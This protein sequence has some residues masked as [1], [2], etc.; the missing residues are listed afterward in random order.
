MIALYVRSLTTER[1]VIMLKRLQN[2]V[3]KHYILSGVIACAVVLLAVQ[4]IK[5]I[6][7]ASFREAITQAIR[8]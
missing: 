7:I 8:L 2:W 3:R 6:F 5:L 4:G 1:E